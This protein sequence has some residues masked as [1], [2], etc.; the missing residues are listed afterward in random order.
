MCLQYLVPRSLPH[1]QR[2]RG[3]CSSSSEVG[4][5][6][7]SPSSL[8]AR[9]RSAHR[10]R[11]CVGTNLRLASADLADLADR[12]ERMTDRP[13]RTAYLLGPLTGY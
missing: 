11:G 4:A 10:S 5:A 1:A 13:S 2:S 6:V 3:V 8:E 12:E 9:R 7:G